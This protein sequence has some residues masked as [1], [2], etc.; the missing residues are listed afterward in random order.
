M[1]FSFLG[2]SMGYCLIGPLALEDEA[3]TLSRNDE[4]RTLID[5]V[6]YPRRKAIS[7]APL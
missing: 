5:G 1:R 6:R 2:G 3:T 7:S 4:Y